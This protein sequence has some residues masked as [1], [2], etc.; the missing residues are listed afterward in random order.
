MPT[1]AGRRSSRVPEVRVP[2]RLPAPRAQLIVL[3]ALF[4]LLGLTY[5]LTT[6][7]FEA[8]DE[9]SHFLY[10][11][12]LIETRELPLMEDR[13]AQF[14][15]QS[16]QRHHPPLYYLLG[17]ALA[18]G[19]N[20]ADVAEILRPNPFASVGTVSPVN[21]NA[22]LHTLPPA[23]SG[24]LGAVVLL[25]LFGV[26]LGAGTLVCIYRA[27]RALGGDAAGL[28]SA[29][30]VAVLP[31]FIMISSSVTNDTLTIFLSSAGVA[32]LVEAWVNRRFSLSRGVVLGLILGGA[33]LTKINGLGLFGVV[34]AWAAL[35][36][37][38]R[39]IG[40]KLLITP[41][42]AA[43]LIAALTAGW[44][45][46]RNITLY[47]DPL[48]MEATLRI[49]GRGAVAA[50]WAEAIG[51]WESVWMV[52]GQFN[53]RGPDWFYRLYAPGLAL[54]GLGVTL[55]AAYRRKLDRG[56]VLFLI[57]TVLA[58]LA[59][60]VAATSRLNVSQGRILYP[61]LAAFAPLVIAGMR[62]RLPWRVTVAAL[63]PLTAFAVA[64]PLLLIG[65]PMRARWLWR[66]CPARHG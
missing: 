24:A 21:Q 45:Y 60:L 40:W 25:R 5:A 22:W 48:A 66:P 34:A 65:R 49:W 17:A 51:V 9:A 56:L 23:G 3:L 16:V 55:W 63:A 42:L 58:A 2:H 41:L 26:V 28:A 32:L 1:Q 46:L 29:W 10:I 47:G 52:L 19:T 11:H 14:A 61:A 15:S 6:P 30:L 38:N 53:V 7:A 62:R 13:A 18:A 57:V 39:R 4:M 20:R 44:W 64:A 8:P 54:A 31:G 50:D 43:G 27:G 36:V 59:A 37:W 35:V 12:N 33:A